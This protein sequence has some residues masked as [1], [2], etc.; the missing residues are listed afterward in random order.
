MVKYY[1][2]AEKKEPLKS[3]MQKILM[4][5]HRGVIVVEKKKVLGV[6]TEGDIIK[7]LVENKIMNTFAENIMNKSFKFLK[8]KDMN[9]AKKIFTSHLCSFIPVVDAKMELKDL[10]TLEDYLKKE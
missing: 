6:I 10:I 5:G 3:I 4:N 7:S 9:E 2:I 1:F 8:K